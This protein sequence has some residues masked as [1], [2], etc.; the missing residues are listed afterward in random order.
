MTMKHYEGICSIL[1]I[2]RIKHVYP[3][4]FTHTMHH[5]I[6]KNYI[7]TCSNIFYL[8]FLKTI[9]KKGDQS[10]HVG[11]QRRNYTIPQQE[12]S[13]DKGEDMVE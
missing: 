2:Y 6:S 1:R 4:V 13:T 7:H 10:A 3:S 9:S 5:F 11:V 8:V 12:E